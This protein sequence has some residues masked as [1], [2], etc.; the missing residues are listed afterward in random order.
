MTAAQKDADV[1]ADTA[2]TLFAS[3]GYFFA[4]TGADGLSLD[5]TAVTEA[6][7]RFHG[8]NQVALGGALSYKHKFG[9]GYDV[10]WVSLAFS[11]SRIDSRSA[12]RD[13]DAYRAR[14]EAG[15][16]F[17]EV[18]DASIG[19]VYDRRRADND[20]PVV[21]GISG[22][23]FDLR[24]QSGF[25]RGGY[26]VS[27][28][29][30]LGANFTVRRGDVVS[31]TRQNLDIFLAS[32]A[33]AAD[34][35]FGSDFFAYRLRG[36]TKTVGAIVE[37]GPVES[38]VAQSGLHRRAYARI[39]WARL[40]RPRRPAF[41]R[42]PLLRSIM[43]TIRLLT[44]LIALLASASA[45]AQAPGAEIAAT[46]TDA[47]G[48]PVADAVLIA[49]PVD[50]VSRAASRVREGSIDQVDKEFAPRVTIVQVGAAVSFPNHDDVRHQ[51]Y[52]FSPAKR[53]ELPAVRWRPRPADRFRQAGCR[54]ARL[55]HSRLDGG[56]HLC[57]RIAVLREDRQGR[58][59][60]ADGSAASRI[61]GARLAPATRR[62]PRMRRARRSISRVSGSAEAAWTLKLKP[63]VHVRR[64]PTSERGGAR[65]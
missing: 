11:G 60:A 42:L 24:G 20:L 53:F 21:P 15:Q 31:T 27:D 18:F 64:A 46:V 59:G 6:W 25:V 58:Q 43:R 55:Q 65:Y 45:A 51:V 50:G 36:T 56:I 14:A 34:P 19:Y 12:I 44:A 49:V 3:G 47:Q 28:A 39:R 61:R 38:F 40:S 48:H 23:V 10:P 22:K 54:R 16:R 63:E 35:A 32:D 4:L 52:S 9:V 37:L 57:L 33:I 8:L 7:S 13:S 62:R 26:A 30:A 5:L 17:N 1:R 41:I 29:L 2:A